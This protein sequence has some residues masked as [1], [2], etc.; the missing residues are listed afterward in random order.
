[1]LMNMK[2]L[3]AVA[4]EHYFAIPAFNIGTGQIL[5]TVIESCEEKKAPV[6]L[7]IHPL[8]HDFQGDA[9]IAECVAAANA[10]RVPMAIHLDHGSK[11]E[12]IMRA[13]RTGYT[14][15]MIDASHLSL[16]DNIAAT[17]R[18]VELAHSWRIC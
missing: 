13:I 2:D 4:N 10:S 18:I 3:L 7:A 5:K 9:F 11:F 8:E 16:E 6:I 14:S 1:M 17:K 15:V 12:E